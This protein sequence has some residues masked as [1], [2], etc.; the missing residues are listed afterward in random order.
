MTETRTDTTV[1]PLSRRERW[2]RVTELPLTL[3]AGV[4]LVAYA[5][6]ILDPGLDPMLRKAAIAV[7]WIVWAAFA[8]DFFVQ[9]SLSRNRWRYVRQNPL[10][11]AIVAM[12]FLAPLRALLLLRALAVLNRKAGGALR[13]RVA[14]YIGASTLLVLFVAALAILDAER[15]ARGANID[16]FADAVWWAITT[17]TTVGYGDTYPV[18]GA[19]RLVAAALMLAGI[20]LLGVVTA[21][22]ASWLIDRVSEIE[23]ESQAATKRDVDRLTEEIAALREEL[24][25]SRSRATRT[26]RDP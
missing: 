15:G 7:T 1:E 14:I 26:P 21:S 13:G 20:A 24:A 22:L 11:V 4:F 25:A 2:D 16:G 3:A 9:L 17:M 5:W 8:A 18:T 6:P 23:R 12:P 10:D 19:G